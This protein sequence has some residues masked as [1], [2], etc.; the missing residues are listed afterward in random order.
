IVEDWTMWGTR[1]E[2]ESSG[3][4][5][6]S[7]FV[8]SPYAKSVGG[9]ANS[10]LRLIQSGAVYTAGNHFDGVADDGSEGN[11][12]APLDA[13]PVT[14][15]P[16]AEMADIVRTRAGCLPRDAVDQGYVE[17]SGDWD[18]SE[19]VPFRLGPGA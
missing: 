8:L 14:T 11:A 3:N 2:K 6:N 18:V 10:A 7:L 16:V 19:Y 17:R 13:P 1:F 4:V 9:K 12:T 5:V 15:L